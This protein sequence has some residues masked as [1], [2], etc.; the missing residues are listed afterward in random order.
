[1]KF[2]I[3]VTQL[4]NTAMLD[5]DDREERHLILGYHFYQAENEEEA[6]DQFH[7]TVAISCLDDFEIK[8]EKI[9]NSVEF[10]KE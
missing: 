10:I 5:H 6:L 1:M 2:K 3:T 7:N 9:P 4:A 8:C